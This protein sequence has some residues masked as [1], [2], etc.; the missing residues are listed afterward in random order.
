M[1]A[2]AFRD[3]NEP[4]GDRSPEYERAKERWEAEHLRAVRM[5]RSVAERIEQ[6]IYAVTLHGESPK[7]IEQLCEEAGGY[8]DT[9]EFAHR[10]PRYPGEAE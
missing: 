6:A 10:G 2:R 5:L 4:F 9:L 8:L 3:A 7:R 1:T